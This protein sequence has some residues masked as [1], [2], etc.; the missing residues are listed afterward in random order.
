MS[1]MRRAS[2]M[3]ALTSTSFGDFLGMRA[4]ALLPRPLRQ[5]V[6]ARLTMHAPP[7]SPSTAPI[8]QEV[9]QDEPAFATMQWPAARPTSKLLVGE[10]LIRFDAH[11]LLLRTTVRAGER[12]C[13]GDWHGIGEV[14]HRQSTSLM[15]VRQMLAVRLLSDRSPRPRAARAPSKAT[16]PSRG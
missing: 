15:S 16:G 14:G 2:A 9:F 12:R 13:F 4:G 1:T 11:Q 5:L 8:D 6:P 7:K 3:R 10:C